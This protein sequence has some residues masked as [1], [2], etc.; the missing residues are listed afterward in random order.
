MIVSLI[1]PPTDGNSNAVSLPV[2]VYM[3]YGNLRD[4]LAKVE[5]VKT[6][7]TGVWWL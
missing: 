2:H 7:N 5:A 1:H 3:A 6:A 4:Q